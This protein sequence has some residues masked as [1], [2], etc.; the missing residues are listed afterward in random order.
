MP[1]DV[2]CC[3]NDCEF[4][5]GNVCTQ[6][7]IKINEQQKCSQFNYDLNKRKELKECFTCSNYLLYGGN[8]NIFKPNC[9]LGFQINTLKENNC[10][11][12]K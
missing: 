2:I 4:C 3:S 10:W 11:E 7:K 1:L 8:S 6:E 5:I 12:D 9:K